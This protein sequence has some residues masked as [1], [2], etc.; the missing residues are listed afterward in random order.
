LKD[1]KAQIL[2]ELTAQHSFALEETQRDAWVHQIQ[3]LHSVLADQPEGHI[4]F[5]YSIPRMGRRADVILIRQGVIFVI[6]YKVHSTGYGQ[7]A[8]SQVHDYALDL[9]NFHSESH[10]RRIIPILV[11][12]HAPAAENQLAWA[13]DQVASPLR[14][15]S[16]NL[17]DVLRSSPDSFPDL[18]P[19]AW[20]QGIYKPTPTII[21]AA[22]ALYANHNVR[23]IS[24]SDA[25]AINLSQTA[26]AISR[27]I[28]SAKANKKKAICFVTGVPGSG[29]TLAGLNIAT[30]RMRAAEEEH[31]VFLSG[32]RPLV[33]VLREALARDEQLR[34]TNSGSR[35]TKK[36][37]RIKADAFIQN[38]H[39]F[40]D[41]SLQTD[42][43]P[44]EK[45]AVFDEAQRAW[46][47]EQTSDFMR[48]KKGRPN[49]D[50]SEP[51]F[52][53]SVMDRHE[54]WC[55][56]VCLIGGGQE[57]HSGEAGLGEW[58]STLGK[59]FPHWEIHFSDRID[60]P[61]YTWGEDLRGHLKSADTHENGALHLGVSIRSYRAE[62]VSDFV[63]AV[64]RGNADEARS[65]HKKLDRY[66]IF[67]TRS[68]QEARE[69]L[70][71]H[72]RGSERYGL[73]ASSGGLRLK[74]EGIF[75]KS[76]NKPE[77]W[78]LDGP[79]D[80]RS[81]FALEDVAT[82]FD[83]QGLELD[84]AGVCWDADFRHGPEGWQH[85]DFRGSR[86]NRVADKTRRLYLANSYRVLLTRARQGMV[87]YIPTGSNLDRTRSPN[88]YDG[89]WEFLKHSLA[90]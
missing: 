29:K 61:E 87:I 82:E 54:D 32:N 24:R 25:G 43:A 49:F 88:F 12:T 5:E 50:M 69:W 27:V 67:L 73:V 48:R 34:L 14:A 31:A 64:I 7:D 15:N 66:P 65:L 37:A 75:V 71:K 81:S 62:T 39:H 74:P 57:I 46:N 36:Q 53:I 26:E 2:G 56:I 42:Q 84:W 77:H 55:V 20:Y 59:H 44:I 10:S 17:G 86:W 85:F 83:I 58:F 68:L 89:T 51:H 80:V 3:N 78:F 16:Q 90:A 23:E 70:R 21:E 18:D 40:R 9:K 33:V 72:A 19:T 13:P 28:E 47:R 22:K 79:K 60:A 6:E 45:V 1:G 30:E 41:E 35:L 76:S 4:C 8:L 63:G 11:A 52:L 38:I